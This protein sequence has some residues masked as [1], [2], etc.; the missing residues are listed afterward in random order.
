MAKKLPTP[1]VETIEVT[2]F[3][4]RLT[5]VLNGDINSGFAK[6]TT[7]Y[8]YNPF[9]KPGNLTW[10][11]GPIDITTSAPSAFTGLVVAG[12]QRFESRDQYVYMVDD[13]AKVYK[14]KVYSRGSPQGPTSP[15][16]SV[17]G[18]MSIAGS[19]FSSGAFMEFFGSI[20]KIY[21]GSLDDVKRVN[22]DGSGVASIA[23]NYY[24]SSGGS[25][26]LKPFAGN[27]TFANGNT[28]AVI[29][30]T[31]TCTSSVI[32]TG[33]GNLSS[34]LNP[35]L[36]VEMLVR[37]IDVTIDGNYLNIAAT[38]TPP[39]VTLTTA[40]DDASFGA[41]GDSALFKWNGTD[42]GVTAFQ[43]LPSGTMS[44]LHTYLDKEIFF[45]SDLFGGTL[46]DGINKI[47]TL[48]NNKPPL[49][50]STAVNGNF[51]TWVTP[52]VDSTGTTVNASMYYFGSLDQENAPG[53]YRL[54]RIAPT[55]AS[56]FV[57]QTPF[58]LI[59]SGL[60]STIYPDKTAVG[61]Q[62]YG[63]H[64]FSTLELSSSTNSKKF[65]S[66]YITPINTNVIANE[67]VYETQTQLF[68]KRASIK[69]IRVYT[70]PTV[71]G[72]SFQLDCIGSDGAVITNGSFTYTY[73]AGTDVTKL[74]GALERIN[75]NPSTM[76]TFALGLRLSNLGTKNMT[77]KKIEIDW[78]L[79][80]K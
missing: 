67:G 48:P 1:P 35:P 28:I 26:P 2:N 73:A 22:F 75:F 80:G 14:F 78:S 31:G 54:F 3:S 74:Q 55:L 23:A 66:F 63:L 44:A 59:P 47:L 11:R 13:A 33:L 15:I 29:S 18:T 70:E 71:S 60:Y 38:T 19:D 24:G 58:N 5:R 62:A 30:A 53:L 65:F 45:S 6:F 7:S 46:G 32:G 36:P 20:E 27:L 56:G 17:I 40:G 21:V 57:Y 76:D 34:Q 39:D 10:M 37:D 68:G 69:Q 41:I 43:Q 9:V 61:V 12:K 50:N 79:A 16:N 51:I 49:P 25:R 4:G 8:G 72:N 52:E 42:Q 64:L 77:I